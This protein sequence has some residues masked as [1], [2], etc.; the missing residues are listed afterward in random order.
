MDA[1]QHDLPPDAAGLPGLAQR[2]DAL[3]ASIDDLPVA[4]HAR[5]YA[6][7]HSQLLDALADT[8]GPGA[9]ARPA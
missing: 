9:E 8:D 1:E 6:L 3:L 2:S 7:V 5:V 4:E